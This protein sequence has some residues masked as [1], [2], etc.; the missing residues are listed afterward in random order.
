MPSGWQ[1][2]GK[3]RRNSIPRSPG[4]DGVF[5]IAK[6][7]D[8][9]H[10]DVVGDNCVRNDAGED[11][12]KSWADHYARETS[13]ILNLYKEEGEDLDYGNYRGL[14][15]TDWA[16]KLLEW[17]LDFYICE[18]VNIDE[19]Q[20]GSV[21]GRGTTDAIFVVCRLHKYI[22]INKRLYFAFEP[23][24]RVL[25]G[26]TMIFLCLLQTCRRR[27]SLSSMWGRMAWKLK[28]SVWAWR[29]PSSWSLMLA[30]MSWRNPASTS[31]LSAVMVP[32]ATPSSACSA[33]YG[34]E[35]LQWHHWTF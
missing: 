26:C 11:K 20:F 18:M 1:S 6:Q 23:F 3:R 31:N 27:V 30:M 28:N 8:C 35:E 34:S 10:Q 12:M 24:A 2:V 16:M 13:F 9:T 22:A 19:M 4:D 32:A 21:A 25:H 5:H 29:K 17:V 14:N 7:M 33:S 15:L